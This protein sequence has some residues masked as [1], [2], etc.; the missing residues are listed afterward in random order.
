MYEIKSS[1]LSN[2]DK[3]KIITEYI[4]MIKAEQKKNARKVRK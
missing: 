1:D 4:D 2:G 3:I